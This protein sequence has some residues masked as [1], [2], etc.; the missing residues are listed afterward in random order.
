MSSSKA[1]PQL[2]VL[3]SPTEHCPTPEE[4]A[5]SAWQHVLAQAA[6]TWAMFLGAPVSLWELDRSAS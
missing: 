4:A 2:V 3:P 1:H 5:G 6:E